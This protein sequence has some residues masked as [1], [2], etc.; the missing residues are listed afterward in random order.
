MKNNP[1]IPYILIMAFGIGLIF[2]MSLE[3]AGN[4]EEIAAGHEEG[5]ATEEGAASEGGDT[6]SAGAG[7][8][9]LVSSCIGCHGGDLTGGMGPKL[10]GL[11]AAHIVDVLEN[12]IPGSPMTPGLKTGSEAQAIAD[13]ISSLE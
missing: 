9:E 2:F 13:Y 8:E 1:I 11:D 4:K 5:A 3:G 10:A 12:G 7:G 6:A